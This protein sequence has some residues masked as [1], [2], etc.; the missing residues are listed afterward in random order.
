MTKKEKPDEKTNEELRLEELAGLKPEQVIEKARNKAFA[1]GRE[2]DEEVQLAMLQLMIEIRD[3][4]K[5]G[6]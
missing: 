4:L 3:L 5:G 1:G 2:R 6:K